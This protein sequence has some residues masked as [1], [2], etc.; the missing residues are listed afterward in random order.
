MRRVDQWASDDEE[1]PTEDACRTET[2]SEAR[3][4]GRSDLAMEEAADR[5]SDAPM[6][7]AISVS[8]GSG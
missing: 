6:D 8:N 3:V 4:G 7:L 1:Y 2:M 5:R